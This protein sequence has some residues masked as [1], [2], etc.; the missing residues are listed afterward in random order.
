[1]RTLKVAALSLA[2]CTAAVPAF[3][4][5]PQQKKA[6]ETAPG[7]PGMDASMMEAWTKAATPGEHHKHLAQAAGKWA[8]TQKMWMAP[9]QP[10]IESTGTMEAE[11]ILGGRYLS[12]TYKSTM[13]GE[14]FEGRAFEAYDNTTQEIVSTWIDTAG[15]GILIS[16]GKCDDPACKTITVSG[17]MADPMGGPPVTMKQVTTWIDKDSYKFEIWGSD[18]QGGSM[19]MMEM[20][21]KRQK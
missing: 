10:P 7:M 14:P 17:T 5:D 16:R 15:T 3:S 9:N 11:M 21:A 2:L 19:K 20:T 12:S 6:P 1:M 18:P 4:Q 13:M 8:T